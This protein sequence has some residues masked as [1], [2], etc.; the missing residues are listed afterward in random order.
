MKE[1]KA[2]RQQSN[3]SIRPGWKMPEGA[4][5]FVRTYALFAHILSQRGR[6]AEHNV[7]KVKKVIFLLFS[8]K[9]YSIIDGMYDC[10]RLSNM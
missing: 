8:G 9:S 10:I 5:L 6:I 7:E 4:F 2:P 1:I 3:R